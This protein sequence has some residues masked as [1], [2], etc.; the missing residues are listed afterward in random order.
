[1]KVKE[2]KAAL[3]GIEKGTVVAVKAVNSRDLEGWDWAR[4]TIEN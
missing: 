2:S 1:M 3:S 4:I